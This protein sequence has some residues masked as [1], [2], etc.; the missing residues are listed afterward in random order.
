MGLGFV[1]LALAVPVTNAIWTGDPFLSPYVMFWPYDRLGFGPGHGPLPQGNTVWLGLSSSLAALGHLASYLHGWPTLSLV[2]VVLLFTFKPRRPADLFL[3]AT[4][5]SLVFGYAL[6]WTSGDV[7]GPRYAYEVTSA[8]LVLSAAGIE[9]VWLFLAQKDSAGPRRAVR[10]TSLLAGV[11]VLLMVGNLAGYL[12]W[13]FGRYRGLY[14]V[15]GETREILLAAGLDNALVIVR[16]ENGWKDYAVA[17]S[18][19][20]PTLDGSVVYANDCASLNGQLLAHYPG[21]EVYEFDGR[22]LRSCEGDDRPRP[23]D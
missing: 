2:F 6:Y 10:R 23:G 4:V 11:L 3:A 9:R 8:L 21:R 13:Q 22:E 1:P 7:F 12:P 20:E 16:D 14:G 19:N 17:F 15:T 5:V 18:M